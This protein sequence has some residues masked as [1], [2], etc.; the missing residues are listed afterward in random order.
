MFSVFRIVALAAA[1]TVMGASAAQSATLDVSYQTPQSAFGTAGLKANVKIRTPNDPAFGAGG[2]Y[3]GRANA[4]QFALN[5]GATLGDFAAFCV[6]LSQGLQSAATYTITPTLFESSIVANVD[7]LF[8]SSYAGVDTAIEAAA[9][10][11]ALWEIVHDDG[12]VF[13]L[14]DGNVRIS[15]NGAVTKQARQYLGGL[16]TAPTGRYTLYF[17]A[18]DTSKN[19]ITARLSPLPGTTPVPLPASSLFLLGGIGGL[20]ALRRK[21]KRC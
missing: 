10:Q 1:A 13:D 11:V 4:G 5:G 19:V 18:S 3:D 8:S 21:R 15:G 14:L 16:S 9:F 6:E 12:N 20:V 17:L 7:R 2:L